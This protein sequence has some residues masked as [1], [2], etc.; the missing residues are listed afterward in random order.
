LPELRVSVVVPTYNRRGYLPESLRAVLA[1]S[2]PA[3]EVI[4][5]DDGSSDGTMELLA[6]DFPN[7]R[8]IRIA[9]SGDL[10]AR[11]T[12]LRAATGDIVAFCDSDDL[13]EPDHLAEALTLL[14]AEPEVIVACGNFR[15]LRGEVLEPPDK[16]SMAP[17][18]WFSGLRETAGGCVSDAPIVDRIIRFNPFFP[19]VMCV[20]REAFLARGGWDEGVGRTVGTDFGTSMREAE[21]PPIGFVRKPTALIRKHGGNYSDDLVKMHLGDAAILDYCLAGRPSLAPYAEAIRASIRHRRIMALEV[22]FARRELGRVREI[23]AQL[24]G[25]ALHGGARIKAQVAA[26]PAP[27]GGLV[28]RA[29]LAA[30]TLKARLSGRRA[31]P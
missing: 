15:I 22:A 19:S 11:N 13:W 17:P 14:A 6:A 23:A 27:L 2:R 31:P 30:G 9:N 20:R 4:V 12:G 1:Q 3:D 7:V 8:A 21:R 28:A 18:D 25:Q 5:V 24:G 29:L 16:F 26:L 10:A